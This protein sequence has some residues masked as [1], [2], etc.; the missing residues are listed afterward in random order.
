MAFEFYFWTDEVIDHLAEHDLTAEDFEFVVDN[1]VDKGKSDS[2]G[3]P[4][5]WGYT[6]D[7]RF[8]MA[9]YSR[10]EDGTIVPVTAYEVPEPRRKKK[11]RKG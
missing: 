1:P 10:L 8:I 6:E 4:V 2:S 5:V 9:V 3:R 11:K 7:G